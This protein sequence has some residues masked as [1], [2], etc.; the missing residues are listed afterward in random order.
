MW[1]S[2]RIPV[3]GGLRNL[4][5]QVSNYPH[6]LLSSLREQIFLLGRMLTSLGVGWRL[7]DLEGVVRVILSAMPFQVP[8][9]K[10][11][12]IFLFAAVLP[13][14]LNAEKPFK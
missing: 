3:S 13:I 9:K 14:S 12:G 6:S 8:G 4:A 1:W 2:Y 10:I 11:P 7:K 5:L